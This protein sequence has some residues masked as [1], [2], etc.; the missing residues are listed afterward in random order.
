ML[1][2]NIDDMNPEIYG[3]VMERA[4]DKGALDVFMTPIMMKKNRP[5]VK[6]SILCEEKNQSEFEHLIFSETTT[7]GIR[8]YAVDRSVLSRKI[9]KLKTAYGDVDIKIGLIDDCHMKYSPEYEECRKIAES[10]KIPIKKVY[11]DINFE[12]KKYFEE[13]NCL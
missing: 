5:G 10:L 7:L 13:N 11:E 1:E 2:T 12:A 4:L 3:Y 6:L 9:I 8:K